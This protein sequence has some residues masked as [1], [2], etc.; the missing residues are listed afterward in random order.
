MN[1]Y[2]NEEASIKSVSATDKELGNLSQEI[3]LLGKNLAILEQRLSKVLSP[4]GAEK[5]AK[6]VNPEQALSEIPSLIRESRK[7][8]SSKTAWIQDLISR[9][10]L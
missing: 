1:S 3:D 5:T 2:S 9:L 4:S 7:L 8:V 6:D 10:E